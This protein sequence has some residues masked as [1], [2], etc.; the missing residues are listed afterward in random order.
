MNVLLEKK[1]ES[2]FDSCIL[3]K[4]KWERNLFF[5]KDVRL[6]LLLKS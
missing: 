6:L 2:R 5:L 1:I 4:E 3:K